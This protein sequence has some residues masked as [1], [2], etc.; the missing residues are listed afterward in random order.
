[1]KAFSCVAVIGSGVMGRGIA[2]FFAEQGCPVL[3]HDHD[4]QVLD[5]AMKT[6]ADEIQQRV[7]KGQLT[8]AQRAALLLR[9]QPSPDFHDMAA[10]DL[11]VEAIVEQLDA[12]LPL[13]AAL[14]SLVSPQTILASNTSSLSINRLARDFKH[15]ERFLGMHFFNPVSRMKVIELVRGAHTHPAVMERLE[16]IVSAAGYLAAVTDDS[17]GFII[18]HAGRAYVPEALRLAAEGVATPAQIDRI[19]RDGLGFRMGPFELMD[20]IGLDVV[21][22]VSCSVYE[23][24]FHD[25]RYSPSPLLASRVAAG[26]LGRKT[27]QGFYTYLQGRLQ[28]PEEPPLQATPVTHTFWLDHQDKALRTKVAKVLSAAGAV[29][30]EALAPSSQAICLVTPLGEDLSETIIRLGLPSRRTIGLETLAGFDQRRVLMTHPALPHALTSQAVTALSADGVPVEVIQSSAGFVLQRVVA[31]II[32]LGSE[33]IQRGVTDP[34]T[35]D[36]AVKLGLGYPHGPIEW[37]NR[38]SAERVK[39]ILDGLYSFYQEP[40]Y[41][42][43]PWLKRRALLGIA[44]KQEQA[45]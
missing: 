7:D 21:H 35:L 13:F 17:P 28:L 23:Q 27:G 1:M 5:L 22:A 44:L 15:P 40:R 16:K 26:M 4:P 19:L 45:A 14:E 12:K 33:L 9:I 3:L 41:R 43:S 30:E 32:N 11:L 8:A 6:L 18:N 29:L 10:C 20:L 24:Y 34:D 37:G 36:Q 2:L 39:Q 31:C 38:L 25:P 42:C